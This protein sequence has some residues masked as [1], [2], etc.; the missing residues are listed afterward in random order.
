MDWHKAYKDKIV[1]AEEAVTAVRSGDVVVITRHPPPR[2]L[3][4]AL[5]AR[6]DELRDVRIRGISP[7]YDPGWFQPGWEESFSPVPEIFLGPVARPALDERRIDYSP[8]IFSLQIKPLDE[9]PGDTRKVDVLVVAVSAPDRNGF[10]SFGSDLWAKREL[11]KRAKTVLAQVDETFIRTYGSNYIH[12]SEID[13]LVEHTPPALSPEE[14]ESLIQKAVDEEARVELRR[15]L[16]HLSP[17]RQA[18]VLP[19]LL[20]R[21]ADQIR[22]FGRARGLAEPSDDLKAIAANLS[23]LVRDGDTIQI[24]IG[25]PSAYMPQLGVFDDRKNLGWHS[26]MGAR[27]VVHLV[28]KGVINGSRKTI[29]RGKAVFTGLDGCDADEI[30]YAADNPLIELRDASYVVSIP[31][32]AGHQNMVSI[33]NALSVDLSGQINS[34]TVF[35]ARLYNGTGGQPELH[36]GAV[37]SKGGRAIT[38]VRSTAVGGAVSRIVAQHEEGAVITIPRTFADIVVTEHGVARLLGKSI[39]ERAREL[40]AIAHPDFRSD[41]KKAAERLYYP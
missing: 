25:T 32:V 26:E 41:L 14:A 8:I 40:I 37:L 9:R 30:A 6:K 27:G 23:E 28:E 2:I 11:A 31:T 20:V 7:A 36:I 29:N 22:E 35:G 18:E 24:G 12:V 34:E 16:A 15:L 19:M 3:M 21:P 4:T 17:Q 5:A 1:S 33:N 39:R 38:L 10:C 13:C